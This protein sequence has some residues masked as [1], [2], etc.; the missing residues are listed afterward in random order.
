MIHKRRSNNTCK[1]QMCMAPDWSPT[2]ISCWL[3][4]RQAQVTGAFAWKIR[5]GKRDVFFYN[6]EFNVGRETSHLEIPYSVKVILV[7]QETWQ[8]RFRILRSHI[9]A[10]QSSP[11]VNIHLPSAWRL[12]S[13]PI[14]QAAIKTSN[15]VLTWP[16]FNLSPT[17][18]PTVITFLEMPSKL[19]TGVRFPE[20]R[21]NILKTPSVSVF[22]TFVG[23]HYFHWDICWI[24]F[25]LLSWWQFY[26]PK[27]YV[28]IT[29]CSQHTSI[30]CYF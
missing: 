15:Q 11:P 5:C 21:S 27:P 8:E 6:K 7:Q 3:G 20:V 28:L 17:W 30:R 12:Q 1:F 26:W 10:V 18:K 9:L 19:T 22:H 23:I 16:R 24:F 14:S 29:A 25:H 4:C 13:D 2:T